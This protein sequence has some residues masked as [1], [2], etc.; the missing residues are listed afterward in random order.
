MI[1][2]HKRE[3]RIQ[4]GVDHVD[5]SACRQPLMGSN[6]ATRRRREGP[7]PA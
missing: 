7:R 5:V 4:A 3:G 2:R 6:R 1:D